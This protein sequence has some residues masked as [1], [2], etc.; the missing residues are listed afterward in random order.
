MP[1][2]LSRTSAAA[3]G[4]RS[5]SLIGYAD[6]PADR[7][8][9]QKGHRHWS[10]LAIHRHREAIRRRHRAA[11]RTI[12]AHKELLVGDPERLLPVARI[13]IAVDPL[14]LRRH[15]RLDLDP[16]QER[17][18]EI[19]DALAVARI[20]QVLDDRDGQPARRCEGRHVGPDVLAYAVTFFIAA[21]IER[22]V[23]APEA[24]FREL[25]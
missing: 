7:N 23:L 15:R 10:A 16:L 5:V 2:G 25:E 3:C 8:D 18:A 21:L 22:S 11:R 1:G 24:R 19:E 13:A 17:Q 6:M 14:P 9:C 4:T 12:A 20:E